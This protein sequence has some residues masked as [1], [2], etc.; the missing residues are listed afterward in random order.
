[1]KIL[2]IS[3]L[4][5]TGCSTTVPVTQKF[6]SAPEHIQSAC[7]KLQKLKPAPELSDVAKTVAHNYSE[8]YLCATKVEAW[9]DWYN[10][11]KVIHESLK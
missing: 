5:V 11:Q 6:P 10:Q 3:L 9:I 4:L 7:P 8:Y 1:M 2:L